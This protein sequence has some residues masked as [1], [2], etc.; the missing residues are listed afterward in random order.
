MSDQVDHCLEISRRKI[1]IYV[2]NLDK[3]VERLTRFQAMMNRLQWNF[4]RFS[5]ITPDKIKP[6]DFGRALFLSGGEKGCISS[7][8]EIYREALAKGYHYALIFEDDANTL[9]SKSDIE[10]AISNLFNHFDET[11]RKYFQ[12]EE[13]EI[14]YLGKCLDRCTSYKRVVGN[15][16]RTD[17]PLCQHSYIIS[18]EGMQRILKQVPFNEALD[19]VIRKMVSKRELPAITVHPSIFYQ[20][21]LS[22]EIS[23]L[24]AHGTT[25]AM[26]N[27]CMIPAEKD[28][29]VISWVG[30][31]ILLIILIVTIILILFWPK[32]LKK[33]KNNYLS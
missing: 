21:N 14:I 26:C 1:P 16:Y 15:F 24:R 32:A 29:I 19:I 6:E 22:G 4:K 31:L 7:H 27:E 30:I 10:S 13:P 25:F 5:A 9:I 8:L 23:D 28:L 2:I 11:A 12:C 18:R 17:G 20:D 33:H 3:N